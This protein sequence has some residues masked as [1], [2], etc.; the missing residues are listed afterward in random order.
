MFVV[1]TGGAGSGKSEYAEALIRKMCPDIKE[2]QFIR[3]YMILRNLHLAG[4]HVLLECIPDLLNQK[5]MELDPAS[6]ESVAE[7]VFEDIMHIYRQARNLVVIAEDMFAGV[8]LDPGIKKYLEEM[9]RLNQLLVSKADVFAEVVYEIPV[10]Y[11]G[12]D[13]IRK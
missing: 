3:Q 7:S 6:E 13:R 10:F 1:I 4:E 8:V 5:V 2:P 12:A 11:K 9:G